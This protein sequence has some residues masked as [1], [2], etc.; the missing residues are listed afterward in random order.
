[1]LNTL[2]NALVCS[3]NSLGARKERVAAVMAVPQNCDT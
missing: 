2:A 1:M 3:A